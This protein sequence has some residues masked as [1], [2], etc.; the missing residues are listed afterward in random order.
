MTLR[1]H[2]CCMQITLWYYFQDNMLI[3]E[4]FSTTS[5]QRKSTLLCLRGEIKSDRLPSFMLNHC[6]LT[7]TNRYTYLG[8]EIHQSASCNPATDM[9]KDKACK[10]FDAIRI[11][12]YYF[13]PP[14]RVWLKIFDCIIPLILFYGREVWGPH[15]YPNWLWSDFH[16]TLQS[17]MGRYNSGPAQGIHKPKCVY[18]M[19][20]CPCWVMFCIWMLGREVITALNKICLDV[21]VYFDLNMFICPHINTPPYT[22]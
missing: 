6:P 19:M 12:L 17:R 15:T 2:F 10:T 18:P 9:L 8:L 16:Y 1:W 7:A 3:L 13:Q 4:K 22:L 21:T 20:Y 11:Q 14:V 5:I